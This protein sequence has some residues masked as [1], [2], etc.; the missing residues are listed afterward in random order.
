[1]EERGYTNLR[2][3]CEHIAE[4]E[5]RPGKCRRKYRMVVVRKNISKMKGDNVLF[6]EIRYHYYIT[7]R[8]DVSAAE[9][10]RLANQR[11]DQENP[12]PSSRAV[13]MRC[14]CPSTIWSATGPHGDRDAG[15][16]PEEL[17]RPDDA[18]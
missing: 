15:V 5:Y 10:V 1:M 12:S 14:G 3:N 4:F 8:T 16:E 11:C 18:P 9:V 7:T 17:V 2:L 13:W 6:D